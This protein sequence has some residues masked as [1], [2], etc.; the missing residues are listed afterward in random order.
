MFQEHMDVPRAY[1]FF[2]NLRDSLLAS[3]NQPNFSF[4]KYF[5]LQLVSNK[6]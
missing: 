4:R 2:L 6:K 1:Y 3:F 5:I